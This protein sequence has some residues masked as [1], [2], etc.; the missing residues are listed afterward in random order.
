M[1]KELRISDLAQQSGVASS[2][3]RYYEEI[4]LLPPAERTDNGYRVYDKHDVERLRFIQR[5][6]H[7][8]FSLD[9]IREIMHLREQGEAP[10]AFVINQINTKVTEVERK[11]AQ[12]NQLKRELNQLQT[13]IAQLPTEEV[14]AKHCVCHIIENENLTH[15]GELTAQGIFKLE[16]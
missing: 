15:L 13:E 10:C 1:E 9:E 5:A 12:L 8:D 14:E 4:G 3:I 2:A 16:R 7:L 6:K 11:I